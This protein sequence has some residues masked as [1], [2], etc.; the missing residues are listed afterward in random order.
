MG[1]LFEL[2]FV[3]SVGIADNFTLLLLLGFFLFWFTTI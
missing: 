1:Y 2:F 3:A